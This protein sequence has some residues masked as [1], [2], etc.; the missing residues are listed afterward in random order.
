MT[1][2][3]NRDSIDVILPARGNTPWLELSL[4]SIASQSLQPA[5]ILLID[6][7]L[8]QVNSA[9]HLGQKLFGHRFR[10]IKNKGLG[11]AAALNTGIQQSNA[12]W[13]ARMD[14]DDVAHPNR[15]KKQVEFL[16]QISPGAIGC[17][18]QVRFINGKGTVL[19]Y[20]HLPTA[21]PQIRAHIMQRTC[22]V[23][24]SLMIKRDVLLTTPYR[25]SMD[26]AEDVD[27]VLR[28][29]EKGKLLNVEARLLD[30]RLHPTQE[31]F[32]AR[33]RHTAA[34]ELAFRLAFSRKK[35]DSDPLENT[36]DLA[37][38]FIDWRLSDPDYIRTRTFLTALRYAKIYLGGLDLEGFGQ[39]ML[40]GVKSL[41]ANWW[42]LRISWLIFRKAGAALVQQSTPF[43]ELNI[44]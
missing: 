3:E 21:W 2:P 18:T 24:S 30:Y 16:S 29:A 5:A 6:D 26:G 39:T 43:M 44:C 11:I 31:S 22:F 38:R 4:S 23:H 17:G 37:K 7:G 36:P 28:L 10:L 9:Q 15:F 42:S 32:R 1:P 12:Q 40:V 41:P 25:P 33:A 13:I 34:Q 14:A 19:S 20:S 8:V 35:T 27:L